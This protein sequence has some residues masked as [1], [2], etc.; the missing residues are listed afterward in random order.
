MQGGNS[1]DSVIAVVATGPPSCPCPNLKQRWY[2]RPVNPARMNI[3]VA[4]LLS[5]SLLNVPAARA[6]LTGRV[7][8]LVVDQ[9][10]GVIADASV[11]LFSEDRVR[12]AKTDQYGRF[13]FRDLPEGSD[14]LEVSSPGFKTVTMTNIQSSERGLFEPILQPGSFS[15]CMVQD[16]APA[17]SVAFLPLS[18]YNTSYEERTDNVSVVGILRDIWDRPLSQGTVTLLKALT[19]S[20]YTTVTNEKGQF[21]FRDVDPG[22]YRLKATHDG[23]FV[24]SAAF[25]VTRENLARVVPIY[26]STKNVNLCNPYWKGVLLFPIPSLIPPIP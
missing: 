20:T 15:G 14:D 5:A 16:F 19:E 22:K 21:R 24:G 23:F 7:S 18:G 2:T 12:M 11:T 17:P 1:V 10:G 4:S 13:D 25:W 3:A 6:Q 9:T 26:L 8:G